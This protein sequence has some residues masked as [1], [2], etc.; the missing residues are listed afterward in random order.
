[1]KI[2]NKIGNMSFKVAWGF[3]VLVNATIGKCKRLWSDTGGTWR[4]ISASMGDEEAKELYRLYH[5]GHDISKITDLKIKSKHLIGEISSDLCDFFQPWHALRCIK[6][7]E[8]LEA[9]RPGI[10]KL[11]KEFL[12]MKGIKT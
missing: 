11:V 6:N 7:W 4:T 5:A 2:L 3:D 1:M 10:K 9:D 12:A 8:K